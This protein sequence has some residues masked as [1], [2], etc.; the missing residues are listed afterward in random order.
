[1]WRRNGEARVKHG[2]M[3]VEALEH[4]SE[5]YRMNYWCFEAF[6]ASKPPRHH[7][8]IDADLLVLRLCALAMRRA[9][10]S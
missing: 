10:K 3:R 6:E 2:L 8:M 5:F 7:L 1:M 9:P 4:E